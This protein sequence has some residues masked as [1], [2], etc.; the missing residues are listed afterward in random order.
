M[1]SETCGTACGKAHVFL[2]HHPSFSPE[3][4]IQLQISYLPLNPI[5]PSQGFLLPQT[6]IS[7]LLSFYCCRWGT[8]VPFH[9]SSLHVYFRSIVQKA[10]LLPLCRSLLVISA[11][12]KLNLRVTSALPCR[13]PLLSFS[14]AT[15]PLQKHNKPLSGHSGK[16]VDWKNSQTNFW[17]IFSPWLHAW[18]SLPSLWGT[19]FPLH[20]QEQPNPSSPEMRDT[21]RLDWAPLPHSISFPSPLFLICILLRELQS[22]EL[23]L[24]FAVNFWV[25]LWMSSL[26]CTGPNVIWPSFTQEKQLRPFNLSWHLE[27]E[28]CSATL[29]TI[30]N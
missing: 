11:F 12:R 18:A 29:K 9:Y 10:Y 2:L 22:T 13:L 1:I 4:I 6:F 17:F 5:P 24:G 23:L 27:P 26:G 28:E 25:E 7:F 15:T 19:A 14:S 8:E 21:L 16:S 3:A 30:C 20:F